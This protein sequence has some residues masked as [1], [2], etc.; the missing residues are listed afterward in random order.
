MRALTTIAIVL[1]SA[2]AQTQGRGGEQPSVSIS[3]LTATAPPLSP[4]SL[5]GKRHIAYYPLTE[6]SPVPLAPSPFIQVR[7]HA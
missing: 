1:F 7:L 5:A 3:L 4:F 2:P 6:R